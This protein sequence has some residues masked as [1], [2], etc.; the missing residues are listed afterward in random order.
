MAQSRDDKPRSTPYRRGM[1][2]PA[3]PVSSEE[4]VPPGAIPA[5]TLVIMR[6]ASDGGHD[7]IL[8][9]KRAT[10]MAFA[11]GAVVFP[12]GRVDPD[13][14]VVAASHGFA[15]DP[16]EGAARVAALRETL[17]ET[18]LAVGWDGLVEAD[19]AAVRAELLGGVLLSRILANRSLRLDL[20]ALV[21]FARWCP[22]FSEAR[23]FDTRFYAV[24]A[25]EHRHE[26]SVELAEHSQIFWQSAASALAQANQGAIRIIFPTRRNLEKLEYAADFQGILH[27]AAAFP[28]RLVT[29]WVETHDG[30]TYLCIPDDLGYPVSRE[31]LANVRRS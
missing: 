13:D 30:E 8:L 18:G 17:E 3:D 2:R 7:E 16:A 10:N 24:Q 28:I 26:L 27:H 21:P 6:P 9:V 29:P 14:H 1:N 4:A 11:A 20:D 31:P 19:I 25:P 15:H 12:G 5:A 22:N 23:T